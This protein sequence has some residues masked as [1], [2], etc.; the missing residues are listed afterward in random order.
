MGDPSLMLYVGIPTTINVSH[1]SII[2]TGS[3]SFTVNSE[4]N[5]HMWHYQ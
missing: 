2:P 1:N 5:S 3:T 4:E